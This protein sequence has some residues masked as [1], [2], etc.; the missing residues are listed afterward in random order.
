MVYALTQGNQLQPIFVPIQVHPMPSNRMR[1]SLSPPNI[2]TYR[3]YIAY[4]N[5]PVGGK[6]TRSRL[7]S[8]S[9]VSYEQIIG[10]D[11][12]ERGDVLIA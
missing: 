8:A 7:C 4:R 9:I 11:E 2:G 10:N 3:I 1:I 5:L 6:Y 12:G